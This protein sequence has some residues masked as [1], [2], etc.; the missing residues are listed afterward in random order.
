MCGCWGM[1]PKAAALSHVCDAAARIAGGGGGLVRGPGQR[2]HLQLQPSYEHLGAPHPAPR[3]VVHKQAGSYGGQLHTLLEMHSSCRVRCL[4]VEPDHVMLAHVGRES[5]P[6][7]HSEGQ[8]VRGATVST[9]NVVHLVKIVL[10]QTC[11]VINIQW[12]PGLD[13]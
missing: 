9:R 5:K 13:I 7:Y 11:A 2:W 6:I 3:I 10:G 8:C 1:Q 12:T 4:L